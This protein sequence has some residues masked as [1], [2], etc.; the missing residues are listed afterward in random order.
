[1]ILSPQIWT[2]LQKQKSTTDFTG[3]NNQPHSKQEKMHKHKKITTT[4]KKFA[5]VK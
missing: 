1:M 4:E 5:T 3:T 2:L